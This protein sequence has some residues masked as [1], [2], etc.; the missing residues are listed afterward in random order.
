MKSKEAGC[1]SSCRE[2]VVVSVAGSSV[3]VSVAQTDACGGC[4]AGSTCQAAGLRQ[5]HIDVDDEALAPTLSPGDHVRVRTAR[6]TERSAVWL[7]FG[8]PLLLIAC[9]VG[10]NLFG[11]S[12]QMS[13][14][15][16]LVLL[17]AYYL[18]LRMLRRHVEKRVRL[19]I[20]KIS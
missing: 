13:L 5:R 2:G 6:H 8:L 19:T 17:A 9:G 1:G 3:R 7:A 15:V 10:L 4:E 14:V 12:E 18:A 16:A 11:V 20:E